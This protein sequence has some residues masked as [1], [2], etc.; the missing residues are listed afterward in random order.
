MTDKANRPKSRVLHTM[1]ILDHGG[2]ERWLI[3]LSKIDGHYEHCFLCIGGVAGPWA[4][5]IQGKIFTSPNLIQGRLKFLH[6]LYHFIKKE[7]FDVVH[8]HHYRF[9]AFMAIAAKLAGCKA[10][11]CHSHSDRRCVDV[12]LPLFR[13]LLSRLYGSITKFLFTLF[14][15]SLICV[16]KMAGVALFSPRDIKKIHQINCGILLEEYAKGDE[17]E[18]KR[19]RKEFGVQSGQHV[20][21]SVGRLNTT[22]NHKLLLNAVS[23][24]PMNARGKIKLF[25][26]GEGSLRAE[27]ENEIS[28]KDLKDIVI[29]MGSRDDIPVLMRSLADTFVFPSLFEGLGLALIEAQS[30]GIPCIISMAIPPS[31]DV[32]PELITRLPFEPE[33]WSN[34]MIQ[35]IGQ[36]PPVAR[37]VAYQTVNKSDFSIICNRRRI[38]EC[39]DSILKSTQI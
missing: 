21:M 25:I 19:L 24:M 4:H 33:V 10:V 36:E 13:R 12:N 2:M 11:V 26:A 5:Y 27:L 34:T 14:A 31:A 22:K 35:A 1:T 7:K 29:L 32:V 17:V 23:R 39:Y 20:F 18:R 15:D 30:A 9:S 16:S 37:E 8:L 28:V 3:D 6:A 38:E